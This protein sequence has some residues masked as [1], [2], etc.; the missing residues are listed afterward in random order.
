MENEVITRKMS[1]TRHLGNNAKLGYVP[2]DR[3]IVELELDLIDFS[4]IKDN[5]YPV[6]IC[7]LS[8]GVGDQLHWTYEYLKKMNI[9]PTAYY[10]ELSPVRYEECTE[11]YPYMN[12]LNSDIFKIKLGHKNGKTLNRKVFSII[13]NNCPYIWIERSGRTVRAEVEFFIKNSMW[14]INGGIQI[15]EVPIHRLVETKRFLAMICYRYEIFI[16]KFPKSIYN[17]YKQVAVIC[18]KKKVPSNE[19][20]RV[21]QIVKDVEEDNIPYLDKVD[22]KVF[23]VSK[24]DFSAASTID[25]FRE[26]K[27]TEQTLYNGLSETLDKLLLADRKATKLF[28]ANTNEIRPLIEIKTA[29][30]S[31]LLTAGAYDGIMGDLLIKGGSN[32]VIEKKEVVEEGKTTIINTEVLKPYFELTNKKGDILFKEF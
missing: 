1:S 32:K 31:Q 19:P 29:H 18:K 3:N 17:S 21:K 27:I 6:N 22:R 9:M 23:K 4:D 20:N 7:D 24:E 16:A 14:D 12:H 26:N 10:N 15:L 30:L 11:K 5:E 25:I 13:R 8:G 2:T 28:K